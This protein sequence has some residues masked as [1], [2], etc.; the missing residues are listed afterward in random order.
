M[1]SGSFKKPGTPSGSFRVPDA[2]SST[3][4]AAGMSSASFRAASAA[5]D[6]PEKYRVLVVDDEPT[7]LLTIQSLLSNDVAL[8]TCD[9]AERALEL[10]Q[11]NAFHVV[12]SDLVLP[13]M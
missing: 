4:R 2:S 5:S 10:L 11:S 3:I 6:S 9:S 1:S 13:A 12:I 8:L 7:M